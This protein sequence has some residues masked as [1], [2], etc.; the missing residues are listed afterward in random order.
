[1]SEPRG[2][3]SQAYPHSGHSDIGRNFRQW[4]GDEASFLDVLG[5]KVEVCGLNL[6]RAD[7]RPWGKYT[8]ETEPFIC[9]TVAHHWYS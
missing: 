7:F 6:T 2:Y 1:M 8:P 5:W 4:D 9:R 3:F